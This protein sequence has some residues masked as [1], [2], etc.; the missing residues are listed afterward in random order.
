MS[1]LGI[2]Q[3]AARTAAHAAAGY[4]WQIGRIFLPSRAHSQSIDSLTCISSALILTF[5]R[6][7]LCRVPS[8]VRAGA[9]AGALSLLAAHSA[10]A[11][12]S[13]A[14]GRQRF[15]GGASFVQAFAVGDFSERVNLA[16]G[17]VGYVDVG[18]GDSIF[19]V[20][21]EIGYLGYGHV[22]RNVD[23]SS[24]IPEIPHASLSVSTTNYMVP[25]HA[26][27][28]AQRKYGRWRP[29]ADVLFGGNLISTDSSI[30]CSASDNATCS[31]T[32]SATNAEDFVLSIG[33]AGGVMIAFSRRPTVPRLD[34]SFRYL[35][36]GEGTYLTKGAIRREG[37]TAILDLSRSRTDMVGLYIGAVF[38][39]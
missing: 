32:T 25:M 26:R 24:L 20:G 22:H 8:G 28:R 33:G 4:A 16:V 36:G 39:R 7:S 1:H 34:L 12:T 31:G 14:A 11:Q 18:L 29:Y 38:G 15:Q 5:A 3:R 10:Y 19:S 9:V 37:S 2:E 6:R 21:G 30:D 13:S 23:V 27:L 17:G 35:R